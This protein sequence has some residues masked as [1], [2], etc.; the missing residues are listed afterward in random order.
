MVEVSANAVK[1]GTTSQ[2]TMQQQVA[3]NPEGTVE[4]LVSQSSPDFGEPRAQGPEGG[5]GLRVRGSFTWSGASWPD[6]LK[7]QPGKLRKVRWVRG[8]NQLLHRRMSVD[9]PLLFQLL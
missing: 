1:E 8:V 9:G 6:S 4:S 3:G 5:L 2:G 7:V